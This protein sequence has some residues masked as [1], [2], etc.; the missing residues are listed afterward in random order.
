MALGHLD[1]N[2]LSE[3]AVSANVAFAVV[4]G[5]AS[6]LSI[7]MLWNSY[8][9]MQT[10]VLRQEALSSHLAVITKPAA[11][12]FAVNNGFL[13]YPSTRMPFGVSEVSGMLRLAWGN[14]P[15][16]GFTLG[17]ERPTFLHEMEFLRSAE[18]SAFHNIDPSGPQATISFQPGVCEATSIQNSVASC[19][20]SLK[21]ESLR[22]ASSVR[23][24]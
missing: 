7:A 21:D 2:R 8:V 14:R 5:T 23:L 18:G 22:S 24:A 17:V 19:R 3:T 6:I 10:R 4:F 1:N 16:L 9:L 12:V 11:T 13:D 20:R 15:F